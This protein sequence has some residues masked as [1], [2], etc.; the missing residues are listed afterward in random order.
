MRA[1]GNIRLAIY[2]SLVDRVLVRLVGVNHRDLTDFL[3]LDNLD[4]GISRKDASL[5]A[6][7]TNNQSA[8]A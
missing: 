4:A 6:L 3:W 8:M 5:T 2:L 1:G 7:E